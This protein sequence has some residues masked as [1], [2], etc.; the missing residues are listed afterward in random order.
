MTHA[1]GECSWVILCWKANEQ[2]KYCNAYSLGSTVIHLWMGPSLLQ[3][4][5]AVLQYAGITWKVVRNAV[6][7][8]LSR[9]LRDAY[10]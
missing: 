8:A 1:I 9:L 6:A 4:W 3:V 2:F 5:P 7:Q 10:F